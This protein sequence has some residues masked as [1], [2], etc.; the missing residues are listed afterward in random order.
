MKVE[1]KKGICTICGK[2]KEA[3]RV[4]GGM[5]KKCRKAKREYEKGRKEHEAHKPVDGVAIGPEG[6]VITFQVE[7]KITRVK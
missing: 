3:G 6:G 7:I 2:G 1:L 5:H 4:W